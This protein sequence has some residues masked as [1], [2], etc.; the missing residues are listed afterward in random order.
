MMAT[1]DA[2]SGTDA[3]TNELLA[4]HFDAVVNEMAWIVLRSAH[5]TFV[6]ETQDF[7]TGLVTPEGEVFAT[8]Y[9]LGA[10]SLMGV[11]M[12][13]GTQGV[14]DWE[15]GDVVVT[16]DPY[17]TSGMVM[18]L[19]DL[20]LFKPL[21]VDGELLCFA[22][23]FIHCTDVGGAAPGSIDMQ[24]HEIFQEGVRIRPAKLYRRG[25]LDETLRNVLADNCRIPSLNWGD[26]T[27]LLSALATAE[28]RVESI[29][30]KHGRDQ[31]ARGMYTTLA[32]TE[33]LTRNVLRGI[34]AGSYR[35]E[36]YFED[37]YVTDIPVRIQLCLTSRGD[38]TVELDFE[39]SDPQVRAALN[40]PTGGHEHH[41]FHSLALINFVVTNA[42]GLHV[43][44][45]I[46]RCV[47]LKLPEASVVNSSFPAACGMRYSTAMRIHDLVLGALNQAVPGEVPAGGSSQV[48]VTYISTSE[49]DGAGRV[50]VAN[51]VQGGSGGGL[52]LD[53]V[54]GVDFPGAHLRNV[55]VEVLEAE[56]P[57]LVRKL[58]LRPDS[59]G[60]GRRRGGLGV[61]YAFE[62]RDNGVVVVMRGTDRHR[63]TS[64]GSHGGGAGTTG[65]SVGRL[66]GGEQVDIGKKTVYRARLG[67]VITITSGGGGGYGDPYDRDP[68]DVRNDYLDGLV[69]ARRAREVYGVE[70]RGGEVEEETTKR[71]RATAA[72][73]APKELF[74][75]GTARREWER[76][77][78]E[79]AALLAT[80]L[81]TLPAPVRRHAQERVYT[82]LR[83]HGAGPYSTAAAEDAVAVVQLELGDLVDA[84]R[85]PTGR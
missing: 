37:D 63:F 2:T 21:F 14:E 66:D 55:P 7:S 76:R 46:L 53:G 81:P 29:C 75:Y 52:G 44:A 28:R 19:N 39:G 50:V 41:P 49:L 15:P 10:N 34:P 78:G 71:L 79:V 85:V 20:Y 18:H 67:E 38:G 16:N 80:W 83:S 62:I 5:T 17:L 47:D 4:N 40:L 73:S 48:V 26:V 60:P 82:T 24:N 27:A 64:W 43:N 32:R 57:V 30:G 23:S 58:A 70:L 12:A 68:Q 61:E 74:D 11:S 13:A 84:V 72:T 31:V 22:W 1:N 36:E 54:S 65:G 6:R 51:P 9:S 69:S 25:E 77:Y 35:F 56:A 8:P 45:G 33:E 3:V 42:T 59:E